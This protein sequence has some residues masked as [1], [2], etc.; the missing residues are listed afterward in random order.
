MR[1]YDCQQHEILPRCRDGEIMLRDADQTPQCVFIGP[2]ACPSAPML[3]VFLLA[4][5]ILGAVAAKV[6]GKHE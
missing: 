6:W 4:A 3:T 2:P 1:Y 5:L